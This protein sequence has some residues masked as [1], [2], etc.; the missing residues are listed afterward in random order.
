MAQAIQPLLETPM[1]SPRLPR[2]RPLACAMKLLAECRLRRTALRAPDHGARARR[3]C[4]LSARGGRTE[5]LLAGR[6]YGIGDGAQQAAAR[7]C[8]GVAGPERNIGRGAG[9]CRPS[10]WA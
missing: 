7:A 5:S 9:V 6:S 2:M 3:S 10:A 8:G 4:E 1:I